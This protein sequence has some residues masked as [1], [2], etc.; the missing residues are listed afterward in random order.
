VLLRKIF[1]AV[2]ILSSI[3]FLGCT[4]SAVPP[5]PTSDQSQQS[6]LDQTYQPPPAYADPDNWSS[7]TRLMATDLKQK[8]DAKQK[9]L[10]VD[11]RSPEEYKIEHIPGAVSAPFTDLVSG[12]WTPTGNLNDQIVTY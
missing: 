9:L 1:T 5:Q 4:K 11:V 10:V 3:V 6:D 8:I 12:E 7:V 2:F